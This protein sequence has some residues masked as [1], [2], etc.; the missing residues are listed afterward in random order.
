M[1]HKNTKSCGKFVK[2]LRNVFFIHIIPFSLGIVHLL[3]YAKKPLLQILQ[4]IF[5]LCLACY[6]I[7]ETSPTPP[8]KANVISE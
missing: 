1:G 6:K 4:E 2:K 7:L 5:F 3:R 8:Q